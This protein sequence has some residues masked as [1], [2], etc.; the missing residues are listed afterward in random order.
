MLKEVQL[1][2]KDY[3]MALHTTEK[4]FIIGRVKSQHTSLSYFK[5][6]PNL[7]HPPV[8]GKTLHQQKH[9]NSL[10]AQTIAFFF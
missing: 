5:K 3:E 8:Q 1:Q 2:E 7:Q 6:C 10:K 9:S 4:S